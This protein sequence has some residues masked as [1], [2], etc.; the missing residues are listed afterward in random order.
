MPCNESS[1]AS[2]SSSVIVASGSPPIAD[3]LGVGVGVGAGATGISTG[4]ACFKILS[5]SS[6]VGSDIALSL[7]APGATP[8][9]C[10][11]SS[12]ASNSSSEMLS[13]EPEEAAGA[14]GFGSGFGSGFG[15]GGGTGAGFGAGAGA[16]VAEALFGLL[17]STKA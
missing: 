2:N 16:G 14:T 7:E 13:I 6:S 11:E 10:N 1:N 12:N 4:L 5:N 9:P 15:A 3:T 8:L 17:N